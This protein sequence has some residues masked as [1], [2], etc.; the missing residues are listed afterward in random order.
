MVKGYYRGIAFYTD[1]NDL[2]HSR[3]TPVL[4]EEYYDI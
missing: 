2:I 4:G 3:V 1:L